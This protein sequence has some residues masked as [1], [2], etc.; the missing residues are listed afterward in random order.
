MQKNSQLDSGIFAPDQQ[1]VGSLKIVPSAAVAIFWQLLEYWQG[2]GGQQVLLQ[3]LD[4]IAT[5]VVAEASVFE[6]YRCAGLSKMFWKLA[7][8]FVRDNSS[9]T[10]DNLIRQYYDTLWS[11]Q[12]PLY[13]K[14]D[15]AQIIKEWNGPML[16]LESWL[17]LIPCPTFGKAGQV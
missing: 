8:L 11:T 17:G 14:G 5:V 4:G 1:L 6:K 12:D 16:S 3:L 10:N 15:R 9:R 7:R 2:Q 13:K